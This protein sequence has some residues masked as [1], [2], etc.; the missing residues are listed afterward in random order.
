MLCVGDNSSDHKRCKAGQKDQDRG[1]IFP[2]LVDARFLRLRH[3]L[4]QALR[5]AEVRGFHVER[6]GLYVNQLAL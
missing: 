4:I 1:G 5:L 3:A 6:G 2:V